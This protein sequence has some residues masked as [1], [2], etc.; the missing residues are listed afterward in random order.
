MAILAYLLLSVF[1]FAHTASAAVTDSYAP[2]CGSIPTTP[3]RGQHPLPIVPSYSH[4][5]PWTPE[6]LISTESL[7]HLP[8]PITIREVS[9]ML[10]VN[11]S[12]NCRLKRRI[13]GLATYRL[14]Y[15][16]KASAKNTRA[17]NC[18]GSQAFLYSHSITSVH[19]ILEC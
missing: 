17:T 9:W 12:C 4:L 6:S 15:R 18:K 16:N 10:V 5:S 3:A 7:S 19:H 1:V 2:F 8:A 11:S 14:A 13:E